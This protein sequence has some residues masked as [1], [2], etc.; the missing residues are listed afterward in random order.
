M[1]APPGS[2]HPARTNANLYRLLASRFTQDLSR[3]CIE[4]ETGR[5]YTYA[6]LDRETARLA[7][8]FVEELGLSKG[9][10]V[11]AHVDKSP[12]ALF[13]YLAAV[14][15][16]LVYLPFNTA[17][18]RGEM[19]YFLDDSEPALVVCRPQSLAAT[20]GLAA[21]ARVPHIY[22]LDE[23]GGGTLTD[24]CRRV[25]PEFDT[26]EVATGDLASILYTSGTTG[27]SKGAMLTHG[28]LT[29]NALALLE[30]WGMQPSDVL[31]HALPIFHIHGLFVAANLCLLNAGKMFFLRKFDVH[32]TL[33]YLPRSTVFM[34]VP[35]YYTRLLAEP[36]LTRETCRPM[37]LFVSGSAPLLKETFASF[38]ARTGHTILE[39][40]G[41][42]ETGMNTSNPLHGERIGGTVG[43]PL[44]GV[45]VR[46]V[47]D[48]DRAVD[49]DAIGHIQVKGPNV[50]IGYWRMPDKNDTDFSTDGYFRTGDMG[51]LDSAGYLTIVGRSKDMVIS[52][53][54]N[55]YPKEIEALID[56]IPGVA[57]SAV[58]GVPHP[59]FG[60]AVMAVVVK[61]PQASVTEEEIIARLKSDI[62]NYKIP[63]R[64][65][66]L[67][68]LPRNAMGK[69]QKNLL[70]EMYR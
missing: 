65:H 56:E 3:P 16:G 23:N 8:F 6:D 36:A 32:Q 25:A 43:L 11:A 61:R 48:H 28:N 60:E 14:R 51:K 41:M 13:L 15:A 34:G 19:E 45:S 20:K 39:R 54:Y 27:R 67:D 70:R 33:A 35:T 46:V 30:F 44:P 24:G 50:F 1:I 69:V 59:D 55:V 21:A 47:D 42:S 18:Q 37:R 7:R 64:I 10:R 68:D 57:E 40:Y 4:T 2:E 17:Y 52:G 63:K 26:V 58:I 66:F 9:A 31:L 62:A 22:T 38:Q 53:G 5:I 29:S 49:P 12:Q